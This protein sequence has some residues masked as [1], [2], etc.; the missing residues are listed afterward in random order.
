MSNIIFLTG[1][2]NE[3]INKY[4]IRNREYKK[5]KR[6]NLISTVKKR[7]KINIQRP[8]KMAL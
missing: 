2:S 3:K 1:E 6:S 8:T 7:G 4:I 5:K